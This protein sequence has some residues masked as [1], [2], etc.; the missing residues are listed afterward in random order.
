M[1]VETFRTLSWPC[2]TQ[3]HSG[4]SI[5]FGVLRLW[6]ECRL[7]GAE[8]SEES[9]GTA[10]ACGRESRREPFSRGW[11]SAASFYRSIYGILFANN[12]LQL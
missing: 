3:F 7:S 4:H 2:F 9:D 8:C 5:L 1:T 11:G 12:E 10:A 6:E